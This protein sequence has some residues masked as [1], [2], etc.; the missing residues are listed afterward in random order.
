MNIIPLQYYDI[1][2]NI[3]CLSI[4]TGVAVASQMEK[5]LSS[6]EDGDPYHGYLE[7]LS[8]LSQVIIELDRMRLCL[9]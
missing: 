7:E 3:V 4:I 8:R 6:R 2:H 9:N 1:I 5:N